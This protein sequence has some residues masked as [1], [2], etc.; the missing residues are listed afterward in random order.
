M[1]I[2]VELPEPA[3]VS[4]VTLNA[5]TSR[6]DYPRGYSIE[7]SEDGVN[8]KSKVKKGEGKTAITQIEFEEDAAK[9]VKITQTGEHRLYWSIHDLE[10]LGKTK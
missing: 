2:Q 10:V 5:G 8:W 1:W 3:L 9:F 6:S 7:L 4:G